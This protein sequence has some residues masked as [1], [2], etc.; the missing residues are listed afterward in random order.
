MIATGRLIDPYIYQNE[1]FG[2]LPVAARLLF[3]GFISMAES[4]GKVW[5]IVP[6]IRREIFPNTMLTDEEVDWL[7]GQLCK[8]PLVK[9]CGEYL[10]IENW[11]RYFFEFDFDHF[12]DWNRLKKEAF[13]RDDFACVYCGNPP[14][15]LDHIIARSRGGQDTLNNL[16]AACG[17]CNISKNYR[18]METWY[19]SRPFFSE[20][21]L[22]YILSIAKG[23]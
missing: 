3:F 17:S 9:D 6:D 15:H 14:K 13:K 10:Q 19:R 1:D 22:A 12:N 4:D 11:D 21:R 5:Y 23:D 20:S 18:D 7:I 8:T 16:V 2:T